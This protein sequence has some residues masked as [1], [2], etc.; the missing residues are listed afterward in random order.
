MPRSILMLG[1][2]AQQVVAIETAKRLGYRT[3][4]C[5]YLPDN[6]GQYVA[7]VFYQESTTDAETVLEIAKKEQVEGVLA[8]ASDPASPI[9]A[10]VA[11]QL[12]LPTNPLSAVKTMS[13][14]HL[15]RQHL[16]DEGFPCPRSR[17]FSTDDDPEEV[18]RSVQDFTCPLV[19]KPTDSSGSKGVSIVEERGGLIQAVE[20]AKRISRNGTLI[21]EEYIEMGY[22]HVIGGDIFVIDGEVRFWGLMECAR[23]AAASLV[24][25]GEMAPTS[26]SGEQLTEVKMLLERLVSSLGVRFGELNVE[27]ILGKDNVPYVIELGSRAGGNM[28]PV[29]LSDMSGIDLVEA[30]ILCAMGETPERIDFDRPDRAYATHVLHSLESGIYKGIEIDK[31]LAS[32]VYRTALYVQEGDRIEPFDGAN[33]AVGIVFMEFDS[34]QQMN[35]KISRINNLIQVVLDE[36]GSEGTK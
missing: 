14:K 26:L 27:V 31:S 18:W 10:Y 4:L 13:E 33:R 30:N 17:A 6:P 3:V 22:P 21:V 9:A 24:P 5:D 32:H 15:F 28:I 7:D 36:A 8:Y 29:Q 35:A 23:D 11:E 25:T 1:G 34:L 19:V 16:Q 20:S 12:D 2:S